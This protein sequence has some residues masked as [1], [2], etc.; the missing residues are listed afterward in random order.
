[1]MINSIF[2]VDDDPIVVFGIKKILL[3]FK[4]QMSV[5]SFNNGEDAINAIYKFSQKEIP[6]PE[7]IFLDIN[8]PIMDGW[9]F[10]DEFLLLKLSKK[11]KINIISSTINPEDLIKIQRYKNETH[12][13]IEFNGKPITKSEI[14]KLTHAA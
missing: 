9:E 12:H 3:Q 6:I 2:I 1:M 8:M 13:S 14:K 4:D 7:V 11:V 5:F 10:L